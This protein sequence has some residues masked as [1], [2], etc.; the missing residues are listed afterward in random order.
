MLLCFFNILNE[1]H[2]VVATST[3]HYYHPVVQQLISLY[4]EDKGFADTLEKA[5][6]NAPTDTI[7]NDLEDAYYSNFSWAGKKVDDLFKIFNDWLTHIPEPKTSF[8]Y[9]KLIYKLCENNEY[10]VKFVSSNPGLEWTRKFVQA[11]GEFMDSK[12]SISSKSMKKWKDQLGKEWD[13]Y[14]EPEGG[15]ESFNDFF[16]RELRHPRPVNR[17]E[18]VVVSPADAQIN[19]INYNLALETKINTK[20][21]EF[22]DV[23]ELLNGSDYASNFNGGTAVSAVLLPDNYHHYHAPVDGEIVE[24]NNNITGGYFGME[25]GFEKMENSGNYGGWKTDFGVFGRYHRGYFII[26]TTDYGYVAMIPVGL[27]DISSVQF[28]EKF[29]HISSTDKPVYV[30]KGQRLGNF[31]YGGSLVI[32]LFEQGVMPG[33]KLDQGSKLGVM[34]TK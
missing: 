7:P 5:L 16:T 27:D 29:N 24:S 1:A 8:I 30:E 34:S 22:L 6:E 26:K 20:Y 4:K 17:D 2:P 28:E 12:E 3:K 31:A 13:D 33:I 19:M 23:E 11:R 15:F 10:A 14:I 9:Y 18:K 25:G 32:L 21:D